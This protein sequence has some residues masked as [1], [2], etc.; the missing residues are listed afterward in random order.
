MNSGFGPLRGNHQLEGLSGP[1]HFSFPA[2]HQQVSR[3]GDRPPVRFFIFTRFWVWG[4]G[5]NMD[6]ISPFARFFFSTP[7]TALKTYC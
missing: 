3:T 6:F 5:L 1:F 4:R 2:E 7:R